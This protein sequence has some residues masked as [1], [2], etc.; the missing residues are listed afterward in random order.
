MT[1]DEI[2]VQ[3]DDLSDRL[4]RV[5]VGADPDTLARINAF[6]SDWQDFYWGEFEQWPQVQLTVFANNLP[7]MVAALDAMEAKV[8]REAA[9][10]V[11]ASKGPVIQADEIRVGGTWPLWMKVTAGAVLAIGLYK[12]ARVTRLL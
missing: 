10:V 8:G 11:T 3:V 4:N 7:N 12:V 1:A 2:N 6:I 9:P 5:G